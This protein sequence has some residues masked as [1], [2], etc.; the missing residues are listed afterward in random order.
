MMTLHRYVHVF[1]WI[2]IHSWEM[3]WILYLTAFNTAWNSEFPSFRLVVKLVESSKSI[4]LYMTHSWKLTG[5]DGFMPFRKEFEH[6][7]RVNIMPSIVF[8][9]LSAFGHFFSNFQWGFVCC[10]YLSLLENP[11]ILNTSSLLSTSTFF[12]NNGDRVC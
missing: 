9:F 2:A 4:L 7:I 5:R 1:L 10:F 8:I 3:Q 12:F 6:D 11:G